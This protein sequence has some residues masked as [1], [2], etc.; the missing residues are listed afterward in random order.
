MVV[1]SVRRV[2]LNETIRILRFG[3]CLLS[4]PLESV[5]RSMKEDFIPTGN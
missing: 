4:W 3:G 1:L 2:G 5:I